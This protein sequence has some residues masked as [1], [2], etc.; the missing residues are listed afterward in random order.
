MHALLKEGTAQNEKLLLLLLITQRVR[1]LLKGIFSNTLIRVQSLECL[2]LLHKKHLHA[3][4]GP[5]SHLNMVP[6]SSKE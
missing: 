6:T 3:I 1:V 5:S 4:T 2:A